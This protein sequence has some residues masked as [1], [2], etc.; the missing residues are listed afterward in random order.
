MP[1]DPTTPDGSA[2]SAQAFAA[3]FAESYG[4][5]AD[6]EA[7]EGEHAA[8]SAAVEWATRRALAG[9]AEMA[10]AMAA[11]AD[12]VAQ[13]RPEMLRHPD[14]S[15]ANALRKYADRLAAGPA[16]QPAKE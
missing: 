12:Q 9:A 8:W 3:W 13:R 14:M 2:E 7:M 15:K 6:E 16:P 1:T 11:E 5:S 10:R 4:Y